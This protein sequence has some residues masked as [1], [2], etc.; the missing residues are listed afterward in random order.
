MSLVPA[1][2]S[3]LEVH[4]VVPSILMLGITPGSSGRVLLTA[5]PSLQ[6]LTCPL[7]QKALQN[8]YL[9]Q[10]LSIWG[11]FGVRSIDPGL[12]KLFIC[13]NV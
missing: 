1:G 3:E 5:E 6:P 4:T 2:A 12:Y 8:L 13:L 11:S 7:I 9:L 10:T